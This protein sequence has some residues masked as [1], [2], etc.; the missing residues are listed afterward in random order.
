[1]SAPHPTPRLSL[2]LVLLFATAASAWAPSAGAEEGGREAGKHFQRGVALYSEADYRAALVEFK[3]AYALSP[4]ASVLYNVGETEYQLQ[5]YAGALITFERYLGES[6]PLETHRA[7]VESNVDVLKARVGH[8]TIT[9]TPPGADVTIDDQAIGK[10]PLDKA[11]LVS[12]GHRRIIASMAGRL[13]V[14]RYVD[15]ATDDNLSVSL[16]LPAQESAAQTAAT[17]PSSSGGTSEIPTYSRTGATLRTAGWI[18]TG[19]LAA[20]AAAFGILALK[21]S[22]DLK[23]AQGTFPTSQDTLSHYASLTTRYSILADSLGAAALVV[24]G[25]TL[26]STLTSHSS[27][28]ALQGSTGGT[29]VMV[30]P[31][32][33]RLEVTF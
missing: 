31:A 30:G 21:D 2:A 26:V 13:P 9:T 12:V 25:I 27:S 22:S 7:E 20:G 23:T 32:S 16:Q 6:S 15:V 5:D 4:N 11:V 28:A 19:V 3:R 33:A 10:T 18:S 14:T 29:R 8:M 24:G 17:A 1:M